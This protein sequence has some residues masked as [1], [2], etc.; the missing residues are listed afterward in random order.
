[1]TDE[2][3]RIPRG[4]Q[5]GAQGPALSEWIVGGIGLLLL[6]STLAFL[7][8]DAFTNDD[9]APLPAVRVLAIEQQDARFLVR[10]EVANRSRTTAA[11]LRVE[12]ER[13][14]GNEVVERGEIEFEHVPGRSSRQGGMFFTQDPRTL[15]LQI[16]ARSYRQP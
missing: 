3:Q 14:R 12:G 1:M 11:A 15:H 7:V 10:V 13:R 6:L 4:Q 5:P 16:S 8:H 9:Q 2:R